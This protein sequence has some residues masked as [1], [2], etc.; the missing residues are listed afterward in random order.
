MLNIQHMYEV[1]YICEHFF[2]LS[3]STGRTVTWC[4]VWSVCRS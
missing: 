1:I 4:W 3:Y 2:L